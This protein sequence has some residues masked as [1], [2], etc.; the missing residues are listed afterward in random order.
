[1]RRY[2]ESIETNN[3]LEGRDD[4]WQEVVLLAGQAAWMSQDC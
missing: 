2:S 3:A 1:L 4:D